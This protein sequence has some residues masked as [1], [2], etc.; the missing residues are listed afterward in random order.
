MDSATLSQPR[1]MLSDMSTTIT[2]FSHSSF[3]TAQLRK[4]CQVGKE[5]KT[6]LAL[7]KVGRTRFGTH[8]NSAVAL[9]AVLF[10]IH[11]MVNNG[12]V[13]PKVCSA[14]FYLLIC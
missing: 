9:E 2:Y 14:Y 6:V 12:V 4:E 13:N 5:D 1:Q 7:Q 10:N 11:Q 8:F 3:A